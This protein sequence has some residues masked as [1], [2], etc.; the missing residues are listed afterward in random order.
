MRNDDYVPLVD[1]KAQYAG[2][3]EEVHA[4]IAEVLASCQFVGGPYLEQFEQDFAHYVGARYAVGVSSGTAALELALRAAGIGHGDEVIVPANTFVA[5]AEAVSNVGATPVFADVETTTFHLDA[6]SVRAAITPRTCAVIPVHLYGRAIDLTELEQLAS[7]HNLQIIED[8][9]QAHGAMRNGRRVGSSGRPTCFSFYPGKN[10]GACGDAGAVTCGESWFAEKL[11]LLRDHGS[12]RKYEHSI[13]GTNNRLDAIQ[14]A[15]LSSKLRHLEDWNASR[16]RHARAYIAALKGSSICTPQVRAEEEHV[17]H[18]FVVR[19]RQRNAAR[20]YLA[21]S[22]IEAGIHYPVP[23]HLTEAFKAL[24]RSQRGAI[25]VAEALAG[26][27]LSLPMYPELTPHQLDR[28]VDA[29]LQFSGDSAQV[30]VQ[31]PGI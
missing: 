18:L 16:R 26:E 23:L 30:S 20:K 22:G 13:I 15:V 5:T 8:A 29:L 27:I 28:T 21:E 7:T 10:L 12:P 3:Q 25:P 2:I 17:W 1:L 6:D 14:A 4:S 9:A 31:V 24:S 11:Q 19:V